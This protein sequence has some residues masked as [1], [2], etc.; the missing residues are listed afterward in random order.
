MPTETYG[1]SLY[2]SEQNLSCTNDR[3]H[4]HHIVGLE[5]GRFT[6]IVVLIKAVLKIECI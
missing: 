5:P 2:F 3:G 6:A 1:L 4:C